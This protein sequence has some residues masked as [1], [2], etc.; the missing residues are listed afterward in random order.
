M[1]DVLILQITMLILIIVGAV[2]KRIGIISETG[3]K[4]INDL[5]IYLVLPCNIVKSTVTVR[6]FASLRWF[7]SFQSVFRL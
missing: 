3:Q 7:C 4:N 1:S 6:C 5:V 2:I